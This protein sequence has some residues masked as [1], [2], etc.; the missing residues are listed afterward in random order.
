MAHSDT[1]YVGIDGGGTRCRAKVFDQTGR[2]LGLAESGGANVASSIETSK[3]ALIDVINKVLVDAGL[4]N[5]VNLKEVHV[6]GGFAGANLPSAH[7]ALKNWQHPFKSFKFTSDLYTAIIGAHTGKD[8]ALL[9]V[10]TGSCAASWHKNKLTQYGGHGFILGDKGSGAWL[11]KQAV[12]HT[13]ESLDGVL[14]SAS[15]SQRVCQHL[16]LFTAE[17]LTDRFHAAPPAWFGELA[18]LIFRLAEEGDKTALSVIKDGANYLSNIARKALA[19]GER[20]LALCGGAANSIRHYLHKDVRD[21]IVP[22]ARG[23]EWAAVHL[24]YRNK[25]RLE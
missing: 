9:I 4:E 13:L 11:G 6:A 5:T 17:D 19:N 20:R 3:L 25:C 2:C 10:G 15:F 14:H 18:P 12:I 16:Q 7:Q 22:I 21:T 23:P 8:G 1:Y 24:F